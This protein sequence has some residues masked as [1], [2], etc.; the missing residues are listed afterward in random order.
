M[1]FGIGGYS[2]VVVASSATRQDEA[3]TKVIFNPPKF[4]EL[5]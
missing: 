5:S 3:E 4:W 2:L 1:L